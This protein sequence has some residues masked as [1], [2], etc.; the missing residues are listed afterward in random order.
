MGPS[1]EVRIRRSSLYQDAFDELS[2]DQGKGWFIVNFSARYYCT[3]QKIPDLLDRR[4]AMP[5]VI[6]LHD[7]VGSVKNFRVLFVYYILWLIYN[8]IYQMR[9]W[10]FLSHF[11]DILC[12]FIAIEICIY[13][14]LKCGAFFAEVLA[15][16]SAKY[17]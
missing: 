8:K 15:L 16:L 1:I 7:I 12:I 13:C 14:K 4:M 3:V 5:L 6:I 10:F 2:G 9:C 17:F 11:W